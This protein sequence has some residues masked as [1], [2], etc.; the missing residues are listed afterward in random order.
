MRSNKCREMF[1][2]CSSNPTTCTATEVAN[3]TSN[4][5]NDYNSIITSG[6]NV[7]G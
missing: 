7:P 4:T 5:V 2:A 3:Q 6:Y 1:T